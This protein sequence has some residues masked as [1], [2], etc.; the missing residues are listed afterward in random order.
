MPQK[1]EKLMATA[2]L[3]ATLNTPI[4]ELRAAPMERILVIED[5]AALRTVLRRLFSSEG[6][7]VDVAPMPLVVWRDFAKDCQ[8]QWCS[9]YLVRD[10]QD[11]IFARKLR[12]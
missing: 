9:I 3:S 6:Y 4:S 2:T 7:E 11:A 1:E 5:D 8:P 10:L 12:I